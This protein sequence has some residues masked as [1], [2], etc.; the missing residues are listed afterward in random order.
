MAS[1]FSIMDLC[2]DLANNKHSTPSSPESNN[3]V[4]KHHSVTL[5]DLSDTAS[6][7]NVTKD[8]E[9]NSKCIDDSRTFELSPS[10]SP[11]SIDIS[12]SAE[13]IDNSDSLTSNKK[14][15]FSYNALIMMA[16][17][18]SKEKKLTLSGIY[19]YIITNYPF[20]R[21]NKQGWQNSIRHNLSLNKCFV[22]VPRNYDDPGKGNYWMLNAACE[23]EIFIGGST[24]KLRRRPSGFN[25]GRFDAFKS[26]QIP[27]YPYNLSGSQNSIIF[28]NNTNPL[29]NFNTPL[30]YYNQSTI[31]GPIGGGRIIPQISQSLPGQ[32]SGTINQSNI[33]QL[34]SMYAS[35][36]FQ[37]PYKEKQLI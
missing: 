16:I 11:D 7:S 17:R 26:I 6:S 32:I 25:R 4:D 28:N 23:D 13:T 31:N 29:L 35:A 21:D 37:L 36:A 19:D 10:I 12:D 20:Y 2:P 9:N 33:N 34:L 30:L 14:P 22:K 1:K 18:N 27:S 5:D 15:P 3:S 8:S 24:G